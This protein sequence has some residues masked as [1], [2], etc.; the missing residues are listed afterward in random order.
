MR[1]C[2]SEI[3]GELKELHAPVENLLR[4]GFVRRSTIRDANASPPRGW[5]LYK[6]KDEGKDII[7]YNYTN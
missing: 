6:P 7:S 4:D 5:Y 2:M 1:A 3:E